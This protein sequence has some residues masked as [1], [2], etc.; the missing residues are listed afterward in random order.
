[1]IELATSGAIKSDPKI[2]II[3]SINARGQRFINSTGVGSG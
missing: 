1:M 3:P 2:V